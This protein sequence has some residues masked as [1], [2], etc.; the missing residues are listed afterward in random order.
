[1]GQL[2]D[3]SNSQV[4]EEMTETKVVI[5]GGGFGG[6]YAAKY[7]DKTLARRDENRK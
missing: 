7:F 3:F 2:V 5:A 1:V 4:P 6:F